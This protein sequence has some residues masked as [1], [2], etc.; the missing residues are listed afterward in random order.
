MRAALITLAVLALF[1]SSVSPARAWDLRDQ[2][3]AVTSNLG[4]KSLGAFEALA[5]AISHTA[6]RNVPVLAASAGFTYRYD[7]SAPLRRPRPRSPPRQPTRS[8][9]AWG[10]HTVRTIRHQPS[11]STSA[12]VDTP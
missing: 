12:S 5:D 10:S 3:P 1:G 6:P 7:L 11:S 4:I 8:T 9:S 2:I